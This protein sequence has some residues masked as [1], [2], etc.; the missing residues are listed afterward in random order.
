MKILSFRLNCRHRHPTLEVAKMITFT[1]TSEVTPITVRY[2][3]PPHRGHSIVTVLVMNDKTVCMYWWMETKSKELH[4]CQLKRSPN[5]GKHM[6]LGSHVFF[7]QNTFHYQQRVQHWEGDR[8]NY[9]LHESTL[10]HLSHIR[11]DCMSLR[12]LCLSLYTGVP[13]AGNGIYPWSL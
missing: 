13:R 8:S 9:D 1:L 2:F 3:H 11:S 5:N 4:P 10:W 6:S 7:I 12:P